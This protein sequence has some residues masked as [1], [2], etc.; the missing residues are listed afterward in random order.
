MRYLVIHG[1]QFDYRLDSE[2][3]RFFIEKLDRF[4][5]AIDNSWL[6]K[7]RYSIADS[8]RDN[9][10][11]KIGAAKLGYP[12]ICGHSHVPET[13]PGFWNCG[14]WRGPYPPHY[15]LFP[16]EK[17]AIISDLHLGAHEAK[18]HENVLMDFLAFAEEQEWHLY[19]AGDGVDEWAHSTEEIWDM[20]WKPLERLRHPLIT[21]IRGN[22]D[23]D[24]RKTRLLYRLQGNADVPWWLFIDTEDMPQV[25]GWPQEGM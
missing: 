25:I 22:H 4:S 21:F 3:E 24:E 2:G 23:A 18:A 16:Q 14:S 20:A 19:I 13:A 5:N 17:I 6:N 1:H 11:L 7:L 9:V 12:T 10:D 8:D 15:V